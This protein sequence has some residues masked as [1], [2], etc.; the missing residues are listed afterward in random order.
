VN[1]LDIGI[2]FS[3]AEVSPGRHR[4]RRK[5]TERGRGLRSVVALGL[6]VAVFGGLV[7]G[8]WWGYGQIKEY[9][10]AP[11]YAGPGSGE[12]V[13]VIKAGDTATDIGNTLYKNEVVKSAKAFVEAAQADSE[14]Q[15]LQPGSYRL[16]KQMKATDAL[17]LLL[18]PD[19]KI[20]KRF[21]VPEGKSVIQTLAIIS[22]EA[23]IPLAQL[24]AAA[25]NPKVLGVPDWARPTPAAPL[26]L[27]GFLFPDTYD[28]QPGDTPTT[29]LASMVRATNAVM[30][31]DEFERRAAAMNLSAY[32]ALIV[33]SLVEGEGIPSDFAKIARVVYNRLKEPM[34]LEFDSTTNYGRELAGKPRK[35]SAQFTRAE[36]RDP[37]NPYRTH[38]KPGLPPG[39]IANPGKAALDAA[40]LPAGGPW[41]YFVRIDKTGNSAFASTLAD[42]EAN[43]ARS[44]KNGAFE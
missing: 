15:N 41:L 7:L 26:V 21:T 39:P 19:S 27:E 2:P 22:K 30:A 16:R 5:R 12:V 29:I 28:V 40:V 11:D 3:D 9:F 36:L 24:Q 31:E 1:D 43:I 18:T 32:E 6:V 8:G 44:R 33:A 25:K 14:S 17:T 37:S 42:H 13:V 4:R 23:Q 20:F 35:S 34:P 10:T 38:D